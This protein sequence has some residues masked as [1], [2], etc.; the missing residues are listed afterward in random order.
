MD[1]VVAIATAGTGLLYALSA[2][3][4]LG[5]ILLT[6]RRPGPRSWVLAPLLLVF[7][8]CARLPMYLSLLAFACWL[9]LELMA[10]EESFPG[11]DRLSALALPSLC[12]VLLLATG[13]AFTAEGRALFRVLVMA[14]AWSC[15][16]LGMARIRRALGEGL[17]RLGFDLPVLVRST[18]SAVLLGLAD[19]VVSGGGVLT[20]LLAPVLVLLHLARGG[21]ALGRGEHRLAFQ[22]LAAAV[23]WLG[24]GVGVV[25]WMAY[26]AHLANTRDRK[27]FTRPGPSQRADLSLSTEAPRTRTW[28]AA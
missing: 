21:T 5:L 26:G 24:T 17:A 18:F 3:M 10:V 16:I 11:L 20:L 27:V 23:V 4:G 22:R 15:L 9:F 14:G 28:R 13:S 19:G 2:L 6:L 25:G 8:S 7:G 12:L 1:T